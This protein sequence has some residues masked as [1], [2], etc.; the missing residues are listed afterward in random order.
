[1]RSIA[2]ALLMSVAVA[3]T[4]MAG[5]V[6]SITANIPFAFT[7]ADQKFPAGE[8]TLDMKPESG[9]LSIRARRGSPIT[10]RA[11]NLAFVGDVYAQAQRFEIFVERYDDAYFLAKVWIK[12]NGMELQ[13]SPAEKALQDA[14][15]QGRVLK[16]KVTPR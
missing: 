12:N 5:E 11:S 7:A 10:L 4:A 14:G 6:T 1:M 2:I 15:Q 13:T 9:Q 3:A 8:Y 16:L